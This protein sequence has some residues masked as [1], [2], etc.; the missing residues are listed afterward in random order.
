MQQDVFI[1]QI[2]YSEED[3]ARIPLEQITEIAESITEKGLFHPLIVRKA[4]NTFQLGAGL[5]RLLALKLLKIEKAPCHV[6]EIS[7]NE[8]KELSF[9]ENLKRSNL[10]WW[11]E[12]LLV[13][14]YHEFKQA[15][16]GGQ[17][18]RGRPE[19]G[20]APGWTVRDTAAAL[21]KALGA[22]SESINLAKLVEANPQLRNIKDRKTASRVARV[23]AQR[24]NE[25]EEA[26]ANY[27]PEG[28]ELDQV[29]CGDSIEILKNLPQY[30][31]DACITDPPWL[32]FHGE[33][34]LEKDERTHLVF[35]EVFRLLK[36]N[37]LL[38]MFVGI[39]DLVWYSNYLPKLGFKVSK[40]PLIWIKEN[41]MTR[42]GVAA[43][44]YGR[45]FEFILLAAKGTPVLKDA[46]QKPS[47]FSY[48]VVPTKHL[49][50][51]HQKP[52]PLLQNIITDSTFEGNVILDPFA[53]SGAVLEAAQISKRNFVGCEWSKAFYDNIRKRL[54]MKE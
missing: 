38:Y 5:K 4:N 40:T 3:A 49:I 31:F 46:N 47:T 7:E 34:A 53:G 8:L 35:Q 10:E 23:T 43:W 11:Q 21:G 26:G 52:L 25:D 36:I 32:K 42:I 50:H 41:A 24:I 48:P 22:T 9:H 51:P 6:E 29:Y 19:K 18:G 15:Q 14:E 13:K 28:L 17:I 44:E 27:V 1:D 30:S 45:N 39:D 2:T 54:R 12:D 20:A 37:S 16:L 33:A